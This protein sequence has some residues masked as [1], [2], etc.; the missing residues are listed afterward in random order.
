MA[1]ADTVDMN[2]REGAVHVFRVQGEECMRKMVK[3]FDQ[4]ASFRPHGLLNS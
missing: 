2:S 1:A 4:S 3:V